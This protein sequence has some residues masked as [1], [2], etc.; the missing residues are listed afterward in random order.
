MTKMP[1]LLAPVGNP[2]KLPFAL[3]YGA[4]AVYLA[5][6]DFGLRAGAGNFS[7][8]EIEKA[9][10]F[11]HRLGKKVYVAVN[12]FAH[13][14]DLVALPEYLHQLAALQADAL[15]ISDPGVFRMARRLIPQMPIHISTQANNTN[16]E[17]ARFWQELGA[18]R[19]VLAR[20]LT[21]AE[22]K[23]I[24]Q[25][26]PLPVEL[27]V[28]GAMC[29]AYSG[30]CLISNF[31][32]GRHANQGDCTHPC[33]WQYR[34]QEAKRPEEF[35]PVEEDA[36]GS[37]ILNSKDL[38]LLPHLPEVIATGATALKIEGRMKS[39]Y[40]VACITRVYR[41]ALDAYAAE[42]ASFRIR[43]EWLAELEKVSHRAYGSGFAFGGPGPAGQ[44]YAN[45]GYIRGYD[46]AGLVRDWQDGE[47]YFE[48]RN[49]LRL[50]DQIEII[51]PDGTDYAMTI[52]SMRDADGN[53]I[54]TAPHA[55]QIVRLPGPKMPPWAII[56]R[57]ARETV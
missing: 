25:D 1:E 36:R 55:Q 53:F 5:G 15:I 52:E 33:R 49:H 17:T 34:L 23:E 47:I 4:D 21:L 10:H 57:K 40:Y 19:M 32:T 18:K 6:D 16:R 44:N 56:R 11:A 42:G 35:F 48:Q 24:A 54:E 8:P 43:K 50:G 37:Y 30:R 45:G 3:Y 29:M 13:N 39:A 20:E 14:R 46:F 31:L 27:F 12:I 28:H 51:G 9:V 26:S 7:L 2:E 38:C 22:S 41:Q